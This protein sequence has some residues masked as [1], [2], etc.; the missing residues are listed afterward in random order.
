MG[1]ERITNEDGVSDTTIKEWVTE[2]R[3][4]RKLTP[5]M[6]KE[7]RRDATVKAFEKVLIKHNRSLL[8]SSEKGQRLK[9]RMH[10]ESGF[11]GGCVTARRRQI[12][13]E[14]DAEAGAEEV[15][16]TRSKR[17]AKQHAT[18]PTLVFARSLFDTTRL[19]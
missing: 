19:Y 12:Q 4:S 18:A 13:Q 8:L 6:S 15:E 10:V 3:V 14:L 11:R 9:H 1:Q 5:E 16:K 7:A 17:Q 2:A